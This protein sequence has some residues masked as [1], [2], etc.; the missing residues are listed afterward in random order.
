MQLIN[1]I[2]K[3]PKIN[4]VILL[5]SGCL[6]ALAMPPASLWGVLFLTLPHLYLSLDATTNKRRAFIY[7][8]LF[9]FGYFVC[10]LS[11]IGSA[12]LV[13]GNGYRWAWPLAI[14]GIPFLLSFY[15]GCAGALWHVIKNKVPALI[16]WI[17]FT[18]CFGLFELLRGTTFTG[19]P[20][21]VFAY[22]LINQLEI[23]QTAHILS[24][25]G[26]TAFI[27]LIAS[28]PALLAR[29]KQITALCAFIISLASITGA[30]IY[31]SN[32]LKAAQ[33]YEFPP[34]NIKTVAGNIPQDIRWQ[35]DKII[36]HFLYYVEQSTNSD[37]TAPETPTLIVWPETTI[38]DWYYTDKGLAGYLQDMLHSYPNGAALI[39]G[40][41]RTSTQNGRSVTHNS[42]I[43]IDN[44]SGVTNI[45]DKT[46][47]VPFGEYIPFQDIIPLAPVNNFSG[48]IKGNGPEIFT[49]PFGTTYAPAICY[50]II[51]PYS[52]L[53][54]KTTKPDF[55]IN[56]T[57]DAWYEGSAGP[58]QHHAQVVFRAIEY[59]LPIIR[60]ANL[61]ET[62][63]ISPYGQAQ[64]P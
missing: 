60:V 62:G 17:S 40:A 29:K 24:A 7:G 8:W 34:I 49:T 53:P 56:V 23:I 39:T 47:L 4:G 38:I 28:S 32:R 26:L 51:F 22:S 14:S 3:H 2:T 57:N 43:M 18:L 36:E 37:I 64:R 31:G 11:W 63:L 52:I 5:L 19:F 59:N 58:A 55:I 21:N 48:F 25:Y 61:G 20:W 6:S 42:M 54:N 35:R 46:H 33:A 16:Q 13:D 50:E 9:A 27:W 12:L 44:E 10:S 41:L 30:F 45:Y 15:W 1:Y